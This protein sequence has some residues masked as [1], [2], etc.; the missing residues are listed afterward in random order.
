M[1]DLIWIEA[2]K[3]GSDTY[4]VRAYNGAPMG[5]FYMEV[6]G[7]YVWDPQLRGGFIPSEMLRALSDKLDSLNAPWDKQVQEY[8]NEP[9]QSNPDS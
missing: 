4:T 5:E 9:H 1:T 8:F 7:Y 2:G 6:D 3:E